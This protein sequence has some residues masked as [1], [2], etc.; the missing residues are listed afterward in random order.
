MLGA[1]HAAGKDLAAAGADYLK[2]VDDSRCPARM[3]WIFNTAQSWLRQA[4]SPKYASEMERYMKKI[5]RVQE[6]VPTLMF[7]LGEYYIQTRD[8]AVLQ[9]HKALTSRYPAS[10]AR[11]RLDELFAKLPK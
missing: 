9:T 8:A 7:T 3:Y 4:N 6:L 11:D 2:I 1:M 10:S 5:A